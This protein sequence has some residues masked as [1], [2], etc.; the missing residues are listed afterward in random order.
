MKKW[1]RPA[2]RRTK[3][4][5]RPPAMTAGGATVAHGAA[6]PAIAAV[7]IFMGRARWVTQPMKAWA[8]PSAYLPG[9]LALI[10]LE[11]DDFGIRYLYL[12]RGR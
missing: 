7:V 3:I 5:E 10:E 9:L 11:A 1:K 12:A 4:A 2:R 8:S 6:E